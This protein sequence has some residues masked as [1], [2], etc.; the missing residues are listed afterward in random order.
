MARP[1]EFD[2]EQVLERAMQAFWNE[3]YCATSMATLTQTTELKPGSLYAAFKS[4]EGLFL[5]AL[6]HY[7]ARSVAHIQQLLASADTPLEGIRAFLREIPATAKKPEGQRSCFL[8][9]TVLE[10]ARHNPQLRKRVNRH[11]DMIEGLLRG[12]LETA[13]QRGELAADKDP[14]ALAAFIMTSMWG[15]RVRLA[16]GA[17]PRRVDAIV[18]Q[19]LRVLA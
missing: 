1:T 14:L 19:V 7:G 17:A 6:D 3:G 16:A 12:A 15:L 2:R 11:L 18:K 13:R 10:V 8:V 4:K 5:A 9:N